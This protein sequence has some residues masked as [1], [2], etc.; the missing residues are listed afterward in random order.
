MGAIDAMVTRASTVRQ[1]EVS[2][3]SH[4]LGGAL[5]WKTIVPG[6]AAVAAQALSEA[7]VSGHAVVPWGSGTAQAMGA[8]PDR[9][10]VSC[11]TAGMA[12]VVEYE[13][14]DLVVSVGA[15]LTI[16]AVQSTLREHGQ[17]LALDGVDRNATIGG[18]LATNRSGPS[19]LLYGT[20]RDL[21]LGITVA[22]P[23]GEVV[24]SGG[25]VVKNVVGYDLNKLH[26]GA[27]GTLGVICEVTVK[28]HPLPRA[29]AS[30]VGRFTSSEA[31]N[32]VAHSLARSNLALRAV[33]V[34]T[35]LTDPPA[36][37]TT[38][39]GVWCSG[40]PASVERQ[41]REVSTAF[42]SAFATSVDMLTGDDHTAL[43]DR[44]EARRM[45]PCRVKIAVL[46]DKLGNAQLEVANA[47]RDAAFPDGTWVARAG[48]G[49]AH[50]GVRTLDAPLLA[51]LRQIAEA[52]G[53]TCVTEASPDSLRTPEQVWGRP[54][55]DF[56]IM[57]R[58]RDEFDPSRTINPGRFVGAL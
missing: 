51:R 21:V 47:L 53:G 57:T 25:R 20:A 17:F 15:G 12:S 9:Y 27:L 50:I 1:A 56:R 26:I 30:V 34:T 55:D 37:F 36:A 19:R 29:E 41:V 35:D 13:P 58:I 28:V 31:A 22:L 7:R 48:V 5:P 52:A 23:N 40:W 16:G 45:L 44:V 10:D 46:P 14:A 4:S 54:R 2:A 42:R 32:T 11:S 33:D 43:R 24:K 39:V 6:T 8:L 18:V 3:G 49:V 38:S